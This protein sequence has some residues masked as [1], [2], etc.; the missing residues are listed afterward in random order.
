MAWVDKMVAWVGV[1]GWGRAGQGGW[2]K[3]GLEVKNST[4]SVSVDVLGRT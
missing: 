1:A 3:V 4:A 2:C